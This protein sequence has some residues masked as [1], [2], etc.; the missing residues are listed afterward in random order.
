MNI[1]IVEADCTRY[2][3]KSSLLALIALIFVGVLCLGFV[4][5]CSIE[6]GMD[7][8]MIVLNC[9]VAFL[10]WFAI[11]A[12]FS[13]AMCPVFDCLA[14]TD[15][16]IEAVKKKTKE[17]YG[18]TDINMDYSDF[19]DATEKPVLLYVS[20]ENTPDIREQVMLETSCHSARHKATVDV[21]LFRS[22]PV[23]SV[24][25]FEEITPAAA[26]AD[27]EPVVDAAPADTD[28]CDGSNA[29]TTDVAPA[30]TIPSAPA[31]E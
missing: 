25:R 30:A 14:H 1:K 15:G 10:F 5:C 8:K 28:V 19:W 9:I 12:M 13:L 24:K 17:A 26:P 31:A 21:H 18:L 4:A 7:A 3:D 22:V 16:F 2:Q 6:S 11:A 23:D 27:V 29:A 20:F